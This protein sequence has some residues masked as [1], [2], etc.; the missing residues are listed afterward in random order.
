MY[1]YIQCAKY[2]FTE[3]IIMF[4]KKTSLPTQTSSEDE[5]EFGIP[6]E[7]KSSSPSP[8]KKRPQQHVKPKHPQNKKH[9]Q[10]R[11]QNSLCLKVF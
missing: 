4:R 3:I 11:H 10:K 7:W 6:A 5:D 9:P 2:F 1:I 8:K